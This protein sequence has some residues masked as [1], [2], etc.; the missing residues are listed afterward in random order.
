MAGKSAYR[1]SHRVNT[2]A[3]FALYL[4]L[5]ENPNEF[6]VVD[7]ATQS[8]SFTV[9][10]AEIVEKLGLA[11]IDDVKLLGFVDNRL[12]MLVNKS[13]GQV[14]TVDARDGAIGVVETGTGV[15]GAELT[16]DGAFLLTLTCPGSCIEQHLTAFDLRLNA[17]LWVERVPIGMTLSE[18]AVNE[19][20]VDGRPTYSVLVEQ[21]GSCIV[22]QFAKDQ[23]DVAYA[24]RCRIARPRRPQSVSMRRVAFG[25]LKSASDVSSDDG[26]SA[27]GLLVNYRMPLSRQKLSLYVATNSVAIYQSDDVVRIAGVSY[28]G[29]LLVYRQRAGWRV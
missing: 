26:L 10:T 25:R 21:K 24:V 15:S 17:P 14:V 12:I 1:S 8:I 29:D 28:E 4:T 5:D 16:Q 27:A 18:D 13:D 7:P 9:T 19:I 11:S 22:F 6:V 3:R 23:P 20:V 2:D